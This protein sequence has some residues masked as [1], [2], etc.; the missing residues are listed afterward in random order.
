MEA[1]DKELR[2]VHSQA[3]PLY[4]LSSESSELDSCFFFNNAGFAGVLTGDFGGGGLDTAF[5][6]GSS[7]SDDDSSLD[8]SCFFRTTGA[9]LGGFWSGDFTGEVLT[10]TIEAKKL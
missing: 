5:A 4:L 7:S 3:K 9:F 6:F 1:K 2:I 10:G 8:D